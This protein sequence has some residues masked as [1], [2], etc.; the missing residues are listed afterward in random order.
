MF[1][2]ICI[3]LKEIGVLV[4]FPERARRNIEG[5]ADLGLPQNKKY[6]KHVI[7]FNHLHSLEWGLSENEEGNHHGM[8]L[9]SIGPSKI[10]KIYA[11]M[12][13]KILESHTLSH[14]HSKLNDLIGLKV[15]QQAQISTY[16]IP[17]Y[18]HPND[19]DNY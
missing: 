8:V 6:T 17:N 4:S 13:A 5:F 11:V 1:G 14:Y 15:D 7:R 2:E 18:F 16:I 3:T 10:W 19:V 12:L 9:S